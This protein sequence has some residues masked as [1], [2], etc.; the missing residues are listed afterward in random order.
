MKQMVIQVPE[1]QLQE[2]LNLVVPMDGSTAAQ[3]ARMPGGL[4]YLGTFTP[5][6]PPPCP[7]GPS[8]HEPQPGTPEE[9]REY[10]RREAQEPHLLEFR[11]G[12]LVEGLLGILWSIVKFLF[13]HGYAEL[14][15]VNGKKV[16]VVGGRVSF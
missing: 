14:Q 10:A 3:L 6:D 12:S 15:D 4:A 2:L 7:P 8:P 11:G 13:A 5:Q 9:S 16:V 1:E